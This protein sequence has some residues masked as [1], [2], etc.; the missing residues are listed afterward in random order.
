[1]DEAAPSSLLPVD[2]FSGVTSGLQGKATEAVIA[3]PTAI[4]FTAIITSTSFLKDVVGTVAVLGGI[5]KV[6]LS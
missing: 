6:R 4:K 5:V 3:G 2:T 1:M